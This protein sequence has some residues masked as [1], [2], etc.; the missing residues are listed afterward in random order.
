MRIVIGTWKR[1]TLTAALCAAVCA[2]AFAADIDTQREL[3][4]RVFPEVERGNWGAVSELDGDD[5]RLLEQ[6]RLWPDLRGTWLRANLRTLEPEVVEEFLDEYGLLKPA[7]ELRYRYALELARRGDLD[8]YF[9]IYESFYQ[10]M[11]VAE[12]D[13]LALRAEIAHERGERVLARAR[14]LWVVGKSQVDECDPVFA[15]LYDNQHLTALDYRRRYGLAIE[16]REFSL[17]RWLAR[18]IDDAHAEEARLWQSAASDAARFLRSHERRAN[19]AVAHQQLAYAAER[20][21]Y[22]DP[23]LAAEL[24]NAIDRRY[25]VAEE[26]RIRTRRH[27]AL[28]MARDNLP[29][30]YDALV[31][32]PAA[33]QDAEVVRWR[34]RTSLRGEDWTAL[35]EDVA[36]MPGDERNSEEWRYWRA[37]GLKR[38]GQIPAANGELAS[39]AEERSYYGFL[40][41]D[42]LGLDYALELAAL[43]VDEAALSELA[44]REDLLRARE[45]FLV[46]QDGRGRSEWDAVIA[47][48]S[49]EQKAQ[50]AILADRWGW[51]SRA[52]ATA[53]SIGEFDDL[54]LRYPLPY[55]SEFVTSSEAVNIPTTW[56]YGV[57]R[58]ESLFMRDIRSS[59]G[60]VG[61]M[62]LMPSTGRR[63][64]RDIDEPYRGLD[65]LTN[66]ES[67]IR[68]G[69][70]YLARM[71]ERYGGNRVLATAAYNAGPHRVDRWIPEQGAMDARI[72]IE[73]IP[74]NETRSYVRRVMAA[75]TI[76]HWRMSGNTRRLSGELLLIEAQSDGQRVAAR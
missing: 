76:F 47:W 34:A 45:L 5:R 15:W 62:Q 56:A 50:A 38:A 54:A 72:W 16:A 14:D 60:A 55:R 18:S 75:E 21:T 13:C 30:A 74:F 35:L 31:A 8:R 24:W 42:E 53:G 43:D 61:L 37:I 65:T 48:F 57:A 58:S 3:Y 20:L 39:L 17:A 29:G 6:Y 10:G 25:P 40:A 26:L 59:A 9:A 7:R 66:P 46:G 1:I 19:T 36:A 44:A 68:L 28:W 69:T 49:P 73:N 2:P 64:A 41:A 12:L 51:H 27:I 71:A 52:I 63:V 22:S 32:L 11:G 33:G 4:R 67:N 23:Q 70:S